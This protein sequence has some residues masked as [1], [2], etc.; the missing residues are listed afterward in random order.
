MIV[1]SLLSHQMEAFAESAAV[2]S[3]KGYAPKTAMCEHVRTPNA[4]SPSTTIGVVCRG[5]ASTKAKHQAATTT[6]N[7]DESALVLIT[8]WFT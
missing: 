1:C 6:G 2:S 4:S 5:K 7:F 3:S 8:E